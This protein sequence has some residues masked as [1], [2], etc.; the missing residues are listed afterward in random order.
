[1]IL[2]DVH[3]HLD[4]SEFNNDLEEVISLSQKEGVKVILATGIDPDSNKFSLELSKKYDV[5]KAVLGIYPQTKK[6]DFCDIDKEIQFIKKNSHNIVAIGEVGLDFKEEETDKEFQKEL[7][8][9]MINL[10]IELDKPIIIHSRNAESEVLKILGSFEYDKVVLHCFMGNSKLIKLAEEKGYY[11]S[12]PPNIVR[13]THF[14][15]LVKLVNINKILTETDSPFLGPV[16]GERNIPSNV[17]E[18]VKKI[19]EIKGF[20]KEDVAN[21][22]FLNYQRLFF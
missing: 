19:S 2:V 11:F 21:N 4:S 9:K 1:M 6:E 17:I 20:E 18:T 12:V 13:A 14:Q 16:K 22:I 5:I 15:N 3:A 10:A 8:I 7:F